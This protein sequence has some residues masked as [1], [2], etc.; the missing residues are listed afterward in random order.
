MIRLPVKKPSARVSR[1]DQR[2]LA[3][4]HPVYE[5]DDGISIYGQLYDKITLTAQYGRTRYTW[6][7]AEYAIYTKKVLT[8]FGFAKNNT[9]PQLN[10]DI[11][12]PT[13]T[14]TH[15]KV[16]FDPVLEAYVTPVGISDSGAK[17]NQ[18]LFIRPDGAYDDQHNFW[19]PNSYHM[20]AL[21]VILDVNT[22]LIC[23][24]GAPYTS[25]TYA[26]PTIFYNYK[27]KSLIST[28]Y[29]PA[30]AIGGVLYVDQ[31]TQTV[32]TYTSE[33]YSR[34]FI[35]GKIHPTS[36]SFTILANLTHTA[37]FATRPSVLYKSGSNGA[38]LD[39]V[40]VD[41]VS[42]T[43]I[44]LRRI[45]FDLSSESI[46][47][48]Q[49]V[50]ITIPYTVIT[51]PYARG[52]YFVYGLTDSHNKLLIVPSS[53]TNRNDAYTAAK[54]PLMVVVD[55]NASTPVGTVVSGMSINVGYPIGVLAYDR[56]HYLY[57]GTEG[58]VLISVD[59]TND[60]LDT[61]M[62]TNEAVVSVGIDST[63]RI[64]MMAYNFDSILVE[65][66]SSTVYVTLRF[67]SD[68]YDWQG[69]PIDT[70]LYVETKDRLGN[71][72][73][74]TVTLKIVSG[75]ALFTDSQDDVITVT[76][77]ADGTPLA[78]PVTITGPGSVVVEVVNA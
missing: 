62:L 77:S 75:S 53:I 37:Y 2:Y 40:F 12:D 26:Q 76:T 49:T 57:C 73:S 19:H 60:T 69:Q 8:M 35:I 43:T 66:F 71:P 24:T 33:A 17:A 13:D 7:D 39:I 16:A 28:G 22:G 45:I 23:F 10:S 55:W 64:W 11:Q 65:R 27:T 74:T 9:Y 3:V 56:A 41:N 14:Y 34:R 32:Y 20:G 29:R 4:L 63:D 52:A 61:T 54:H 59:T 42:G 48:S 50:D 46:S 67:E 38:Y 44:T 1:L 78:V 70:T 25:S 30:N 58:V 68:V 47:D 6:T 5:F 31:A 36:T 51:D 72:V 15:R 18:I 21:P